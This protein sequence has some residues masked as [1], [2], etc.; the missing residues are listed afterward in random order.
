MEKGNLKPAQRQCII[1]RFLSIPDWSPRKKHQPSEIT[2]YVSFKS[3]L[4]E[5]RQARSC[6]KPAESRQKP[7]KGWHRA[8]LRR[9]QFNRLNLGWNPCSSK[10][11]CINHSNHYCSE[12]V[13]CQRI[14][15]TENLGGNGG[16]NA[17]IRYKSILYW[18]PSKTKSQPAQNNETIQFVK[19]K[20]GLLI[21][22][23]S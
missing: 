13:S 8:H 16:G 10:R 12:H 23:A 21:K 7:F 17:F 14:R 19:Y 20:F 5:K 15:A 4:P 22:K 18:S 11:S 2:Q 1:S 6:L 9:K 3:V